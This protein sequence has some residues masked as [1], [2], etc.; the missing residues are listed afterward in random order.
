M[1]GIMSN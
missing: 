1:N